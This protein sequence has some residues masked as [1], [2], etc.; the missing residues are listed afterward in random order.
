MMAACG[1]DAGN[2]PDAPPA[3]A[4]I[5]ATIDAMLDAPPIDGDIVLPTTC[6]TITQDCPDG[7]RCT[8][9]FVNGRPAPNCQPAETGTV[10]EGAA[11]LRDD[12]TDVD[13]CSIGTWCSGGGLCEPFCKTNADCDNGDRCFQL[14]TLEDGVC[15][16]PCTVFVD[17]TCAAG[18]TCD[19]GF[20]PSSD[21]R[22]QPRCR[23]LG[24]VDHG[25]ACELGQPA[26]ELS[27]RASATCDFAGCRDLCDD[28]HPCAVGECEIF[29]AG[30]PGVCTIL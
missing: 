26:P 11:C 18:L 22:A 9:S 8:I 25:G 28:T 23:P 15:E 24:T 3:D 13:N 5:D 7:Y 2:L 16:S 30:V 27:C 14:I 21:P 6:D 10:A 1:D 29:I 4:A 17:S 19:L 20:S 12:A